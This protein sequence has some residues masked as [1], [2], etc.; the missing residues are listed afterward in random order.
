MKNRWLM[1]SMVKYVPISLIIVNQ[2]VGGSI[3]PSRTIFFNNL[4]KMHLLAFGVGV[5]MASST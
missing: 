2:E 3:P 5:Q 4:K 1:F